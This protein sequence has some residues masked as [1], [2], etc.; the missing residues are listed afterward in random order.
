[1]FAHMKHAVAAVAALALLSPLAACGNSSSS[2]SSNLPKAPYTVQA[3][4]PAWK[5]DKRKNNTLTWYVN[6]DWW[7]KTWNQD[8]I[9]KQIAKDLNLNVKFTIGDDTKLNTLFASGNLPDIIT[10]FDVN[11]QA[12]KKAPQ[13]AWPLEDLAHAYD[14]TFLK[15]ARKDTLEWYRNKNG[16]VYGY[17]SYS[18]TAA[19]YKSGMIKPMQAFIIRKDVRD[20]IGKQ[21]FTTPDGF[22]KGMAAIQQKFPNLI[23]FGFNDFSGGNSSLDNTL[24]DMLGVPIVTKDNKFY[25]RR[26]DKDYLTWLNTLRKLHEQKGISDDSFAD[27]GDAFHEKLASGKYATLLINGTVN[28]STQLQQF[29]SAHPSQ[30]YE[31]IDGMFGSNGRKPTLSQSGISGWSISFITKKCKNPSKAIQTFEYLLSDRGEMLVNFGIKGQTYTQDANGTVHWTP[32]ANK[33]RLTDPTRWQKQYRMGEFVL[34]GHDRFKAL[35]PDSY[36]EA[37]HQMQNWGQKYLKPQFV[38]ENID[39]DAATPQ[40]RANTEINTKWTTTMVS[41]I[42]AKSQSDFDK[43]LA[44]YK[45]FLQQNNYSGVTQIKDQKIADN[46]KKLNAMHK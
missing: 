7:N 26:Q 22:L 3:N 38:I 40:N 28:Q 10:V 2:S 31:A 43:I 24:Q 35:S 15:V 1:M 9:T 11:S 14:P 25:D 41:L 46:L 32:S 8:L 42:R 45:Q 6:A 34:F 37:I 16:K 19:D 36:V 5:S 18:N 21:D 13:W 30:Q 23:P 12:V 20:A 33:V 4:V 44:N 29:A 17:P 27:D 39:P